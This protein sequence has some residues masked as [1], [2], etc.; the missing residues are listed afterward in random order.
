LA[1]STI[2]ETHS[3]TSSGKE[4]KRLSSGS[5]SLR[6]SDENRPN[7]MD[8]HYGATDCAAAADTNPRPMSLALQ[9]TTVTT[10]NGLNHRDYD[11]SPRYRATQLSPSVH[12]QISAAREEHR[13][14]L[15]VGQVSPAAI[16]DDIYG[17]RGSGSETD[18]SSHAETDVSYMSDNEFDM[19]DMQ[20][21]LRGPQLQGRPTL[22]LEALSPQ[23]MRKSEIRL[24]IDLCDTVVSPV[25]DML[26]GRGGYFPDTSD[27]AQYPFQIVVNDEHGGKMALE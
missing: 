14:S 10:G 17:N 25:K 19:E 23:T 9:H 16:N 20:T 11:Q 5:V 4:G 15:G 1:L 22:K 8:S 24:N 12:R 18:D 21:P 3:N 2:R 13:L 7:L 27:N 26:N 6:E